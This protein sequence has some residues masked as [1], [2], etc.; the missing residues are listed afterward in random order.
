MCR[1]S[2]NVTGER[3]NPLQVVCSATSDSIPF[4][5]AGPQNGN[6]PCQ[7]PAPSAN[8]NYTEHHR[9]PANMRPM[10]QH[11]AKKQHHLPPSLDQCCIQTAASEATWAAAEKV[12]HVNPYL[13]CSSMG[14]RRRPLKHPSVYSHEYVERKTEKVTYVYR[15]LTYIRRRS[16]NTTVVR[17]RPRKG[18]STIKRT[19]NN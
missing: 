8:I 15:S 2:W 3:S 5:R 14:H 17:S 1:S 10:K 12:C 16:P 19:G 11:N 18:K 9:G 13:I 7:L 4:T 6:T